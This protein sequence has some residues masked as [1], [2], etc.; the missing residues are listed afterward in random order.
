MSLRSGAGRPLEGEAD[1]EDDFYSSMGGSE[2]QRL[3]VRDQ[4][5]AIRSLASSVERVQGMAALVNEELTSQN[6]MLD[7]LDNDV[8][9]ADSR[10]RILHAQLR[11][12][13]HDQDRG[14][15]CVILIL[16]IVLVVLIM[17]VLA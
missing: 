3:L 9:K 12:L 5:D 13:A 2:T 1:N 6:R 14:K 16:L 11:N 4:N 8:E 7:E 15:Y 10:M 17:L